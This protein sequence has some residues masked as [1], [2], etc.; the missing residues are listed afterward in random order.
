MSA[1]ELKVPPVLV[2]FLFA[3]AMWLVSRL[4]PDIAVSTEFRMAGLLLLMACGAFVG[5]AGVLSFRKANTSVNPL[6]PE[7]CSTLVD[8]G[9]YRY[10]R[11]PMYLALLLALTA[12]GLFLEN[13]YAMALTPA[14]VLYMNRFQIQ[15]EEKALEAV[16]GTA[17]L[18]YRSRVRR[19]L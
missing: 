16:F 6:N 15:P 3:A 10:S 5:L 11:N 18:D 17:F 9:I 12:W 2:T 4:T 13:F 14:F 7:A 8:T 1:L 19:W